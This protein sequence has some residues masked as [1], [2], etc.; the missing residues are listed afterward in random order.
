MHQVGYAAAMS[1]D[2]V[3]FAEE[4]R[5]RFLAGATPSELLDEVQRR[6]PLSHAAAGGMVLRK[7]ARPGEWF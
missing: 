6:W 5:Q 1:A 7:S 4:L 2:D 3:D